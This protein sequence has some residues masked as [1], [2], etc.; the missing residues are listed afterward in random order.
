AFGI[1]VVDKNVNDLD[2]LI[3]DLTLNGAID[4]GPEAN[5]QFWGV[6]ATP[7]LAFTKVGFAG[8]GPSVPGDTFALDNV[9]FVNAIPEPHSL[10]LL[11]LG[12]LA[13]AWRRRPS[14]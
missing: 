5:V 12:G 10:S 11:F 6:I 2:G 9:V 14:C 3:G 13:L 4:P 7:D 1:D 8:L